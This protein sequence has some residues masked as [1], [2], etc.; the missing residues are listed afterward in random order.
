MNT[1]LHRLAAPLAVVASLLA[2]GCG[3]SGN[4]EETVTLRL[5]SDAA[6]YC[7]EIDVDESGLSAT[8]RGTIQSCA[9]LADLLSRGCEVET[10]ITNDEYQLS[11]TGCFAPDDTELFECTLP[12]ALAARFRDAAEIR[13]GCGCGDDCPSSIAA[14]VCDDDANCEV[15]PTALVAAMAP[16]SAPTVQTDHGLPL[17]T[18]VS[19]TTTFCGTCCDVIAE[20]GVSV[21][22][23]D[24]I[25]EL[26][27]DVTLSLEGCEPAECE[28]AA[29][30]DGPVSI[31]NEPGTGTLHVCLSSKEGFSSPA[32]LIN[33]EVQNGGDDTFVIAN[34][35]ALDARLNPMTPPPVL[36]NDAND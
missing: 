34:V 21:T 10:K 14:L 33:C 2:C 25:R 24:T 9:G 6:C 29:G 32:D 15:G 27:F 17:E 28:P 12:K 31:E 19:S 16:T 1:I 4:G 18:T 3:C 26:R 36:V 7:I 23:S 22:G 35:S 11:A 8:D 20:P 5:A 30:I 13:C